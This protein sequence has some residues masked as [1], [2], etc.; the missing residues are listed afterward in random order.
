MRKTD[1]K[2]DNNI[3]KILNEVCETALSQVEGF[4]WLTH[5]ASY[6]NFPE[7]LYIMC[8]FEFNNDLD[9]AKRLKKD[10]LISDLICKKL[11]HI[12]IKIKADKQV[13]FDTQ[14][15]CD[16]QNNGNWLQRLKLK[17]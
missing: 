2:L 13:G 6:N 11:A 16:S 14:Q 4:I 15:N 1:K 12:N 8:A 5:Q 17:R 9:E 10:K 7:T 3:R